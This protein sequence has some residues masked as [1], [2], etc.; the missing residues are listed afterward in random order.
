MIRLVLSYA[1]FSCLVVVLLL[2]AAASTIL[3]AGTE[4]HRIASNSAGHC[5]ISPGF[6]PTP[7]PI[8]GM[9]EGK[10]P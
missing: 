6:C 10:H 3:P 7:D 4:A 2:A 1:A 5:Q 8:F 9:D